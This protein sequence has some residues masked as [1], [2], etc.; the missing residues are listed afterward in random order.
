MVHHSAAYIVTSRRRC[1]SAVPFLLIPPFVNVHCS[2]T[3][4]S[5]RVY[6][7]GYYSLKF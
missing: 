7:Y 4:E 3:F 1:V 6:R 5:I 2:D